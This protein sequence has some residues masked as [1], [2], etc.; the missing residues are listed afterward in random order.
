MGCTKLQ[1]ML[2][3]VAYIDKVVYQWHFKEPIQL[4]VVVFDYILRQ[5]KNKLSYIAHLDKIACHESLANT[6]L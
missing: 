3:T 6:C 1:Y 5:H 4:N 2:L